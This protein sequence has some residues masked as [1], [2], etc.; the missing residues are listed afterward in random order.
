MKHPGLKRIILCLDLFSFDAG[1]PVVPDTRQSL[2]N[3]DIDPVNYRLTNLLSLTTTQYSIDTVRNVLGH[4]PGN[5]Y[6]LGLFADAW[7]S[8][9]TADTTGCWAVIFS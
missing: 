6:P 9:G 7:R 5:H 4:R 3:P 1:C 8:N 2:L